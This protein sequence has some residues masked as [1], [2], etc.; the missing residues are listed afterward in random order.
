MKYRYEVLNNLD[1]FPAKLFIETIKNTEY[2]CE[3]QLS[4]IFV[5]KGE[6]SITHGNEHFTI[7]ADDL[8]LLNPNS[9]YGLEG[10]S[11]NQIALLQLDG[12]YFNKLYSG[13]ENLKIKLNSSAYGENQPEDYKHIKIIMVKL[14]ELLAKRKNGYLLLA[15]QLILELGASLISRFNDSLS[16]EVLIDNQEEE[17]INQIIQY[18]LMHYKEKLSLTDIAAYLN[19][20]PQYVSRYFSKHMGVTLNT[21][22]SKIR[23]QESI[24]D[25]STK[26]KKITYIA[27]E[28]GF[29][30]L[31]SYFK[32][33]KDNFN[34]TPSKYRSLYLE[35]MNS[36]ERIPHFS[37]LSSKKG[38]DSILSEAFLETKDHPIIDCNREG[39]PLNRTW[40]KIMAFGRASECMREELRNQLRMLQKDIVFEY[41]RFHG[42]LSDE[43]MVYNE[44]AR[45]QAEYNFSY[46]DELIDF[47]LKNKLKPFLE[48]GFMPE[49]LASEKI[50]L[51]FWK[52]N[53]SLPKNR[54]KWVALIKSFAVHLIERY[55]IQEVQTWYFEIWNHSAMFSKVDD[56]FTFMKDTYHAIKSVS[57]LLRIG[58]GVG[59]HEL[60]EFITF[61]RKENIVFDFV[62]FVAYLI[63]VNAQD[64]TTKQDTDEQRD[65]SDM[66]YIPQNIMK[67]CSYAEE[68]YISKTINQFIQI[69]DQHQYQTEEIFLSEWNSTPNP[70]D[71]LHDTCFKAAFLVKNILDNF[72]KV[73]G[74]A[75]WAFSDVF[76]ETKTNYATFHGGLGIITNNG[77]KKPAYY[78]YQL[79]NKLGNEILGRGDHYIVTRGRNNSIQILAFH[80]CHFIV[81]DLPCEG[82]DITTTERYHVFYDKT[83]AARFEIKGLKGKITEKIYRVNR[84]N[85]SAYDTWLAIGAPK[86]M[87]YDEV[88]YI[89]SKSIFGYKIKERYVDGDL[90][91]EEKM[92]PHE[93]VLIELLPS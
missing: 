1:E 18:V 21:F 41:V 83:K 73:G 57:P 33:F 25:L 39:E 29:P 6:V 4:L 87:L 71:L 35:E 58:T 32:A 44:D 92:Q 90:I 48:L 19:L 22:I 28:Y 14:L 84:E 40:K 85:G 31:K 59:F 34:M 7:R 45:G 68:N 13:F 60:E 86:T 61:T 49:Q 72:S 78:A 36:D 8:L 15:K 79:M 27:M 55:G 16:E 17:R 74:M 46:V 20:N 3:P 51:F 82:N 24:K 12:A 2:R 53:I 67:N 30:N 77:I 88:N 93:V 56:C 38:T 91:I 76:E 70:S 10:L 37:R 5:I 11:S 9:V 69:M 43:M 54:E 50:Y 63:T 89:E 64:Q 75:Y 26:D 81:T 62:S 47:L 52:A 42:I 80:Y 23:L 66:P 65:I